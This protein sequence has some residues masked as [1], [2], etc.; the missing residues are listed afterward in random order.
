MAKR[1]KK[2]VARKSNA[3]VTIEEG[4]QFVYLSNRIRNR[5]ISGTKTMKEIATASSSGLRNRPKK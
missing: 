1:S 5:R 4:R 2:I 3:E